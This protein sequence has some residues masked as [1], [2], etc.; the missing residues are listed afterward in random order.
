MTNEYNFNK[1]NF[2]LGL[3]L[4][5]FNQCL[6]FQVVGSCYLHHLFQCY[7]A[8]THKDCQVMIKQLTIY[9]LIKTWCR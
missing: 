1:N 7:K 9:I 2:I 3:D 6:I 4:I 5:N 8:V